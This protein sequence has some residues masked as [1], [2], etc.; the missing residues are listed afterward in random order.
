MR[1][2]LQGYCSTIKGLE[3]EIGSVKDDLEK[4]KDELKQ[5]NKLFDQMKA[6]KATIENDFSVVEGKYKISTKLIKDK[7]R[8]IADKKMLLLWQILSKNTKL[9]AKVNSEMKNEKK[10]KKNNI[11]CDKCD[12]NANSLQELMR[13]V[14]VHHTK[15]SYTQSIQVNFSDKSEQCCSIIDLVRTVQTENTFDVMCGEIGLPLPSIRFPPRFPHP[16]NLSP[17]PFRPRFPPM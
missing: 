5:S 9:R 17:F 6:E 16:P 7:Q 1:G 12:A 10:L 2:I 14:R 3:S 13:H 4:C 8:E 11:Q 15:S